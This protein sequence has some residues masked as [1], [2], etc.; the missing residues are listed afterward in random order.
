M[1]AIYSVLMRALWP[2]ACW[3][4]RQRAKV[5]SL[6]GQFLA[7]RAGDYSSV[8]VGGD[9]PLFWVHA[10]SLGETRAAAS[11][12]AALRQALPGWRLLLTHGTATGREEG[13]R[14][15]NE[16]DIQVWVPFDTL[17]A[18][19]RFVERFRPR[20][21]VLLE[22]EVWPN[23]IHAAQLAGIPLVLANARLSAKSLRS[24]E[25]LSGLSR[26]AYGALS[27]VLA[28]TKADADRLLQA[29]VN[30]SALEV[31]GN[32]KFDMAVDEALL[33]TGQSWRARLARPIVMLASAREGEE[34]ALLDAWTT[35]RTDQPKPLLLIVPRHPQRFDDVAALVERR[36]LALQRRSALP[37]AATLAAEADVL[38][39]D[40]LGEMPLYYGMARVALLGGSFAGTGGQNLIEAAACG[41]PLLM[42]PSTYNFAQA[43]EQ[44]V[45]AGAGWSVVD[46]AEG[47]ARALGLLADVKRLDAASV[48]A[49]DFSRAHR[50]AAARMAHAISALA[51]R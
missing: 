44:A 10:V 26:P 12:V 1:R 36:G 41:C 33:A 4:W 29:G 28:Q 9:A 45:T 25:R 5:E 49:Q 13:T 14:L 17:A 18:T 6:Y 19:R 48:A 43:A 40:T 35:A 42:G 15:L 22:T 39:G 7:E 37:D 16:G 2:L 21:G 23:L 11:L 8:A 38:L 3:R 32:L 51:K 27:C 31:S 24:A 30:S 47:V 50:G 34:E 20:V 46:M